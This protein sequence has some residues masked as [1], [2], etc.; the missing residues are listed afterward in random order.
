M[1]IKT[2]AT[3]F[4]LFYLFTRPSDEATITVE[5][6]LGRSTETMSFT[7]KTQDIILIDNFTFINFYL[8][9]FALIIESNEIFK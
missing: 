7:K 8:T 4:I 5:H 3:K 2:Y 6:I 9:L 1:L